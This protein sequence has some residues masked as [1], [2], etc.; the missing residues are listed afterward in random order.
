MDKNKNELN[1]EMNSVNGQ[2]LVEILATLTGLPE[3][4]IEGELSEVLPNADQSVNHLT[5]NQLRE[6][7]AAYLDLVQAEY[8]ATLPVEETEK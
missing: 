7:L 1:D 3:A 5:L 8:L 6:T 4:R 2:N